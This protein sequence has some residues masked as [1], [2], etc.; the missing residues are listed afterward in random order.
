MN[1]IYLAPICIIN[2][3]ITIKHIFVECKI[4][5]KLREE[6]NISQDIGIILGPNPDN[7]ESTINFFKATQI[8]QL[9]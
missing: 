7:E 1:I 2:N 5:E 8:L 9:L 3:T 6:L 4:Y